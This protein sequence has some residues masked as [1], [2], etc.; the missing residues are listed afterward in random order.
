MANA[1]RSR[2]AIRIPD[3]PVRACKKRLQLG[4][5]AVMGFLFVVVGLSQPIIVE[6]V[7]F[8]VIFYVGSMR[9]KCRISSG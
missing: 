1:T 9:P 2:P 7:D 6:F 4:K 3:S 5:M 8:A